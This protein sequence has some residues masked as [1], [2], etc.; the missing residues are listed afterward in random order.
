[1]LRRSAPRNDDRRLSS[2][3]KRSNLVEQGFAGALSRWQAGVF[4]ASLYQ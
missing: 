3:A 4:A 1:L 2:R